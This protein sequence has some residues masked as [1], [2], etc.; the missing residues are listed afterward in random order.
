MS[1]KHAY[2]L[3]LSKDDREAIDWV[4][5]RYPHG[6]DSW[7]LLMD[8]GD[9]DSEGSVVFELPEHVA[10]EIKELLEDSLFDCFVDELVEKL[11]LFVES[12]V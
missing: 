3:E 6:S 5:G 7:L 9:W 8:Y 4:G 2:K 1:E 11:R 12:I 10:W